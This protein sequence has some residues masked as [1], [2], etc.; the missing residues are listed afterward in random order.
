MTGY[1]LI[2]ADCFDL[3]SDPEHWVQLT[4]N[5][6]PLAKSKKRKKS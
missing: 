4:I 5:F 2:N 3:D 6:N 1:V